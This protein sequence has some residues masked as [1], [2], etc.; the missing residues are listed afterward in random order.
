MCA[1]Q[2]P[3][4]QQSCHRAPPQHHLRGVQGGDGVEEGVG[5]ILRTK[6]RGFLHTGAETTS[7]RGV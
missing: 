3:G 4:V 2:N 6:R 1:V 7:S 5:K